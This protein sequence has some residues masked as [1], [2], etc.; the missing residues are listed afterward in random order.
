MAEVLA[1]S[2]PTSALPTPAPDITTP[3]PSSIPDVGGLVADTMGKMAPYQAKEQAAIQKASDKANEPPPPPP[4][5]A[6]LLAM[7]QGLS[8][9]LSAFGTSLATH[10][11]EGGAQEVAQVQGEEQQQ[12]IAAQQA[13]MA[14]K[15]AYIQQQLTVADTNHKLAQNVLLM[16]TLSNELTKSAQA[17]AGEAQRQAGVATTIAGEKQA[18]AIT[19]AE[20]AAQYGMKP[21]EFDAQITG[22][23]PAS[24]TGVNPIFTTR[25]NQQ[26]Q[27]ASA[28][29]GK[30]DPYIKQLQTVLADPKATPKDLVMATNAVK[31]QQQFQSAA[32]DERIKRE[33]ADPLFKLEHDPSQMEGP[34]ASAAIPM[35]DGMLKAETDPDK[36][37]RETRLLAQAHSA[38]K[39]YLADQQS[40]EAARVAAQAGDPKANGEALALGD[41]T[42]S[43]LKSRGSTPKNIVDSVNAAKAYATAHGTTYNATDEIVGEKALGEIGNQTFYGSGRSLVQ[44]G[45]MLD[46]LKNAHDALG[47]GTIPVFNKYSDWLKYQAGSPQLATYKAKVLGAADDYAKVIGGGTPSDS[48]REAA[49][50]QFIYDLNNG[51]FDGAVES[52][53]DAVRSQVKGRIGSNSYIQKREGDILNDHQVGDKVTLKNGQQVTVVKIYPDG[54]FDY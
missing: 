45:G 34:K 51:Q 36:Q 19:G 11:K 31:N 44:R 37:V 3:T 38:H 42:L 15:N 12:K 32:T 8:L 47:N 29:L 7:V 25:A 53:R 41:V 21:E 17:V 23:Q 48:A 35:L 30:D 6:R 28:V 33:N 20:F 2:T 14:Q 50:D 13:A 40:Q 10:G 1:P 46:Q 27:A 22:N 18:Q 43:D 9:G 52:A 26:L 4:P 49:A 16:A 24:G 54:S 39:A 5:H